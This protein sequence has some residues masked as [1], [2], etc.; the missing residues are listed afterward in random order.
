MA[1]VRIPTKLCLYT[2]PLFLGFVVLH[3]LLTHKNIRI[4]T[5]KIIWGIMTFLGRGIFKLSLGSKTSDMTSEGLGELF[6]GDSADTC[7]F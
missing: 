3:G 7:D 1:V 2:R 4:S 6:E 5:K